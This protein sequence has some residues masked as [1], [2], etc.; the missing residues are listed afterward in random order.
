M[1]LRAGCWLRRLVVIGGGAA[2]LVV[3]LVAGV[4][5]QEPAFYAAA[6][7]ANDPI[8]GEPRARRM[9]SKAAAVHA[10]LRRAEPWE[11][12]ITAEE[13]NAWLAIDLPRNH[14]RLLPEGV[15]AP[16]VAFKRQHVLVGARLGNGFASAVAW[17]DVEVRL[18]G[19]NQVGLVVVD[20]RLGGLP[21]PRGAVVREAARR[22]H[23]LGLVTDVRR[24]EDGPLLVVS[25]PATYDA[26][27]RSR[28]ETCG[29]TD[30]ELLLAGGAAARSGVE[31]K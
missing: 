19:V 13:V 10:A 9:V 5:R 4:V 1:G 14:G 27:G 20:A 8:E 30:G 12:V 21:L 3:L 31:A 24:A 25:V 28:L 22:L 6:E 7:A 15:A 16:R 23:A 2:I 11:A 26:A 17:V 18:R 29:V